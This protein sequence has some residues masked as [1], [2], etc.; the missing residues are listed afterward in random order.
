MIGKADLIAKPNDSGT[1][2]VANVGAAG[3]VV[4]LDPETGQLGMPTQEQREELSRI[5]GD[6]RAASSVTF[7]EEHRPDGTVHVDLKGQF[8]DY[9]TVQIGP[10]GSKV[11]HCVDDSLAATRVSKDATPALP[12]PEVR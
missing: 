2:D 4:G 12:V 1:E 6:R 7:V 10:D 8:R 5:G 3:M 9:A 11:F